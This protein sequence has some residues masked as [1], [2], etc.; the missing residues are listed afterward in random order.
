[1]NW[2]DIRSIAVANSRVEIDAKDAAFAIAVINDRWISTSLL[3]GA[4]LTRLV[5]QLDGLRHNGEDA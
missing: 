4:R 2:A 5:V 1:V 3:R